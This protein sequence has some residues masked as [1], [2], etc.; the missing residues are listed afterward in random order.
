MN[1]S[2]TNFDVQNA[3]SGLFLVFSSLSKTSTKNSLWENELIHTCKDY[4]YSLVLLERVQKWVQFQ[5]MNILSRLF[6]A[7]VIN[8]H[9]TK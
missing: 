5:I 7:L 1:K 8:M 6:W 9:Y 2:P 4:I 3:C